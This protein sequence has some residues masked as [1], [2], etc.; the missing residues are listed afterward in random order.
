MALPDPNRLICPGTGRDLAKHSSFVM[1][2]WRNGLRA[3]CGAACGHANRK[4]S[5]MS[6]LPD[7][8]ARQDAILARAKARGATQLNDDEDAEFRRLGEEFKNLKRRNELS[9]AAGRIF[10]ASQ[11]KNGNS[12]T[13][14]EHRAPSKVYNEHTA[15]QG[16]SF[17][18]DLVRMKGNDDADGSAR[19]RL[20]EH[21]ETETRMTTTGDGSTF[22]PPA[23]L[24]DQY[25]PA[26]VAGKPFVATLPERPAPKAHTI[27]VPKIVTPPTVGVQNPEL[28]AV[29]NT[30][31]TDTYA[32]TVL[33][34]V[35]GQHLVSRQLLDQSPI[36]IDSVIFESLNQV[37]AQEQ[38]VLALRGTG[39]SGQ[40]YGLDN[41]AGINTAG[42]AGNSIQNIYTAITNAIATIWSTTVCGADTYF[43]AP[44]HH[45]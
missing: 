1:P 20:A 40:F 13:T 25:I 41:I 31:L 32:S 26:A 44:E 29:S 21:A 24:L 37:W 43:G 28:T 7:I 16:R 9:S 2:Q 5:T 6:D 11:G 33:T 36:D 42:F 12:M 15:A 22:V 27:D 30:D 3:P 4:Q 23:Y 18:A 35:A 17:W 19:R 14:T 38:D 10:N 34:T 39:S 8:R 45:L